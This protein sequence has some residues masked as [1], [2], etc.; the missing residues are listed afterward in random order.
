MNFGA[1]AA[2][3]LYYLHFAEV[4]GLDLCFIGRCLL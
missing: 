1:G 3:L 2:D 4:Q